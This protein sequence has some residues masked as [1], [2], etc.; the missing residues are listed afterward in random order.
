MTNSEQGMSCDDTLRLINSSNLLLTLL[1]SF[2]DKG[3]P[4]VQGAGN[5]YT[6]STIKLSYTGTDLVRALGHE[7]GHFCDHQLQSDTHALD[8]AKNFADIIAYE[9]NESQATAISYIIRKQIMLNGEPDIQISNRIGFFLA[10]GSVSEDGFNAEIAKLDERFSDKVTAAMTA[11][12]CWALA[13][14]IAGDVWGKNF[15]TKPD[16]ETT[17]W[18]AELEEA[19][20]SN[21][22]HSHLPPTR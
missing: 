18:E 2:A 20:G 15:F 7:L 3:L 6:G 10:D 22:K 11:E 12:D 4:L 1:H 8:K 13:C 17:R 16:G 5:L 19:Y 9:M 14:E 21:I